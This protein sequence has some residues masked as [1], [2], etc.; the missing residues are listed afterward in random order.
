ESAEIGRKLKPVLSQIGTN[1]HIIRY[2]AGVEKRRF[3]DEGVQPSEVA[4]MAGA[5][6]IRKAGIDKDRIGVLINSSVCKDFIEPS[7]AAL[8]HGNL[9]LSPHCMNFD[10]GSACLGF[11]DAMLLAGNM[12][13]SGMIEYALIVD[14]ESSRDIVD[15]TVDRLLNANGTAVSQFR[16]NFATLTLGSGAAAAI[17]CRK[18]LA[19]NGHSYNGGFTYAATEHNRLCLGQRDGMITDSNGLLNA[20][21]DTALKCYNMVMD[22]HGWRDKE[23]DE[24]VIHQI[25]SVNTSKLI[26]VLGLDEKKLYLTYPEYGNIGPAAIPITLH[27]A[28]EAGRL[29]KGDRIFLMG[30]ASG[31][32][33]C[34]MEMIW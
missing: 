33:C 27:K 5:E 24:Y 20:G 8:V 9:G 2:L 7:V 17:L 10:V 26:N 3:W 6:A 23:V 12:I 28:D 21:L 4:T 30:M 16:D 18:D 34:V 14:G 22:K 1:E 32:N 19:P 13:E 31:I 15:T 29:K 11:L 25:S